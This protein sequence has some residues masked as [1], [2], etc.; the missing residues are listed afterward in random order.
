M[1]NWLGLRDDQAQARTLLSRI[2]SLFPVPEG[3]VPNGRD[4][5]N[6]PALSRLKPVPRGL[7]FDAV[8]ITRPTRAGSPA[9]KAA[10]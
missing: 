1:S 4:A 10:D 6:A 2:A 7:W 8:P 9:S 5:A 3:G